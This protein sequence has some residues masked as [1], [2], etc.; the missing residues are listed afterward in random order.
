MSILIMLLLISFQAVEGGHIEAAQFLLDKGADTDIQGK[1][2]PS[3][4]VKR[5]TQIYKVILSIHSK[6]VKEQTQIYKVR[7]DLLNL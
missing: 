2:R 4:F 1:S 7:A 6:F 3:K 5:Q